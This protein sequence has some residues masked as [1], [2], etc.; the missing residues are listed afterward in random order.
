MSENII[1]GL[2]ELGIFDSKFLNEDDYV[3]AIKNKDN[4][5]IVYVQG[6]YGGKQVNTKGLTDEEIRLLLDIDKTKNIRSIK[7]MITFFVVLTS[8]SIIISIVSG[9]SIVNLY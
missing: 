9:L 5:N 4:V 7:R 8:I 2:I 6:N 3:D 1:E